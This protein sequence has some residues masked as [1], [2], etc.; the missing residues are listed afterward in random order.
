MPMAYVKRRVEWVTLK[1]QMRRVQHGGL[2]QL[3]H[4]LQ[5]A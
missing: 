5:A 1:V 4:A 2:L 3:A